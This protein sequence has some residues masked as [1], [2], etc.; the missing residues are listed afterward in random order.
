LD[1]LL[2]RFAERHLPAQRTWRPIEFA[3]ELDRLAE[4]RVF[5][6]ALVQ[7]EAAMNFPDLRQLWADLG[8]RTDSANRL[9]GFD[10]EAPLAGIRLAINRPLQAKD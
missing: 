4:L 10:D 6:P 1:Q 7:A 9:Q 3:R 8:L 2:K 5:E